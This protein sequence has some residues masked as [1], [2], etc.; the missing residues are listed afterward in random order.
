[1]QGLLFPQAGGLVIMTSAEQHGAN[2]NTPNGDR[3][4]DEF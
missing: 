4:R 3:I 2:P 1:M